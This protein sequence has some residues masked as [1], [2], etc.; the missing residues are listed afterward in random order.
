ML[1]NVIRSALG[2]KLDRAMALVDGGSSDGNEDNKCV[3]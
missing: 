3:D 1:L 2:D